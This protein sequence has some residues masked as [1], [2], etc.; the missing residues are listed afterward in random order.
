[1]TKPAW[2]SL[3]ESLVGIREYPGS[4]NNPTIMGWAQ[5]TSQQRVYTNDGIAWCG[6]FMGYLMKRSG[7]PLMP[8]PLWARNWATWGTALARPSY[9]CVMAFRR[10]PENGHVA[11]YIS[12]D[13]THYHILGGNQ[14]N[15]V[16]VTKMQKSLLISPRW[17]NG[18]A[19]PQIG[20]VEREVAGESPSGPNNSQA[21]FGTPIGTAPGRVG[22]TVTRTM[23]IDET[24]EGY[25]WV[26]GDF[27]VESGPTKEVAV[28]GDLLTHSAVI[29]TG[30]T[31]RFIDGKGVAR[32]DDMVNCPAHG[33]N[34]IVGP[35][36]SVLLDGKG[37]AV[38]GMATECGA[39]ILPPGR[40]NVFSPG[41]Y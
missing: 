18:V 24:P 8:N 29:T 11:L 39:V 27:T 20:A 2:L 26:D 9:G 6:L 34:K 38:V 28:V 30:S 35:P 21:V 5:Y 40:N 37:I 41:N 1:M 7:Y 23:V 10:G 25:T 4:G 22:G 31:T 17:P 32:I 3:A 13:A 33:L 15:K 19:S 14:S 36:G 12:E 16:C